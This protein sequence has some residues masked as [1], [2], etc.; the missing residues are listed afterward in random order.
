[1]IAHVDVDAFFASVIVRK[2]PR[3]KGKPLLALG[4]GGGCVIAAS[5]E[6]KAKG[7]KTGMT[8]KDAIVLVPDAVK[9]LSDFHEAALASR[10]IENILGKTCPI[11]EQMSIDEWFIDLRTIT[12]G[13]PWDL[14]DWAMRLKKEI[15]AKTGLTVSVGVGPS[16]LLAKMASE[17]RKPAGHTVIGEM[18]TREAFLKDRPAAAIPGIGRKRDKHAAKEGWETAWDIA[19]ADTARLKELY[20]KQ[21]PELQRELQGEML[22]EVAA[23][24]TPP[25]S[26]SRCRSFKP[27]RDKKILWG[28]VLKH[29]EYT[30]L[31]MR[32]DDLA[33]G[34]LSVWTRDGEYEF[35]GGNFSLQVPL[36]TAEA[37]LPY[38]RRCFMQATRTTRTWTQ[39]GLALFGL[40]PR[41]ALQYSLLEKPE[42]LERGQDLQKTLDTLHERF[43]R[44]SIT[45]GSALAVKTGTTMTID[46]PIYE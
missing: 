39:V 38:V 8:L 33:C 44:S 11:L 30:V 17:Y 42:H 41:G 36:D 29:L 23:D 7:V 22:Y 18:I 13:T 19:T 32:R 1:V 45:R 43:G 10:E 31:K 28:H 25:K 12:G 3:L 27:T 14:V 26:V 20:G 46:L 34:L 2:N 40:R 37:L 35:A 21:G 16:K 15:A 24:D 4:M 9:V 5:Y 6:A